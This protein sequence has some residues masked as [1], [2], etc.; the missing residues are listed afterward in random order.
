MFVELVFKLF[1][2]SN[3]GEVVG[4]IKLV[5]DVSTVGEVTGLEAF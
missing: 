4:T 2:L 1:E 5:F 3:E